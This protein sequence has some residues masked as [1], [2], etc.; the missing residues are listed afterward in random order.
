MIALSW[1]IWP[2]VAAAFCLIF[3]YTHFKYSI[4]ERTRDL[5]LPLME[6]PIS[7][8]HPEPTNKN[9]YK[10]YFTNNTDICYLLS[11]QNIVKRCILHQQPIPYQIAL[12]DSVNVCHELN[13]GDQLLLNINV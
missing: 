7:F 8:I 12:D 11:P 13:M 3:A 9:Q 5:S 1:I 10:V 4:F 2:L 6:Q